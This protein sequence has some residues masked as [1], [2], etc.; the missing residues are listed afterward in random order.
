VICV[1]VNADFHRDWVEGRQQTLLDNPVQKPLTV[2]PEHDE[3][4]TPGMLSLQR[5]PGSP[6]FPVDGVD[7]V[8]GLGGVVGAGAAPKQQTLSERPLQ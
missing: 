3:P 7:G 1:L 2:T 8:V 6:A 5:C 4:Q